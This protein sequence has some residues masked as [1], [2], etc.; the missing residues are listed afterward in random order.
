MGTVLD[1]ANK[2]FYAHISAVSLST[3]QSCINGWTPA[4]EMIQS[5]PKPTDFEWKLVAMGDEV[6]LIK[7]IFRW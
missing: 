6:W 2:S 3:K 7:N 4:A 1:I 5:T